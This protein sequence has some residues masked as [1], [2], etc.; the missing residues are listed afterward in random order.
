MQNYCQ[1][2]FPDR[3]ASATEITKPNVIHVSMLLKNKN[4]P[5]A[6]QRQ[7]QKAQSKQPSLQQ[8]WVPLS[9]AGR[10][11][12]PTTMSAKED[13]LLSPISPGTAIMLMPR[14]TSMPD[15]AGQIVRM[16]SDRQLN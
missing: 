10:P 7:L 2:K 5:K 12:Q 13:T 8:Q 3:E 1:L 16:G 6:G 4:K 15:Y 14:D 9:V 11:Q